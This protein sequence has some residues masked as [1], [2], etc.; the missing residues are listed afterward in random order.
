[1]LPQDNV[2]ICIKA[3]LKYYIQ[4][5]TLNIHLG[6]QIIDLMDYLPLLK[7]G[8]SKFGTCSCIVNLATDFIFSKGS[9]TTLLEPNTLFNTSFNT[10][11]PAY[12]FNMIKMKT[13]VKQGIITNA[14][15]TMQV[16]QN[17]NTFI[18]NGIN[19]N[20]KVIT[21][22]ILEDYL[23]KEY[24]F[25]KCI[26]YS[27]LTLQTYEMTDLFCQKMIDKEFV[28]VPKLNKLENHDIYG[29]LKLLELILEW[30]KKYTLD[31]CKIFFTDER[32]NKLIFYI[33]IEDIDSVIQLLN[34]CYD[35]RDNYFEAYLYSIKELY[36]QDLDKIHK[37]KITQLIIDNILQKIFLEQQVFMKM[38]ENN[39]IS[40]DLY[41]YSKC[42]I[43]QYR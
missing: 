21:D 11:I 8:Y 9:P 24:N 36:P 22:E 42:S 43:K 12:K 32:I 17:I 26:C 14:L 16:I 39:E 38:I 10:H 29:I 33:I 23:Q 34:N 2:S 30:P 41:K 4:N 25:C 13:A 37:H 20:C 31:I 19:C 40:T 6:N 15:N 28:M 35:P 18:D 1:M 7:Q 3:G 5:I 27:I